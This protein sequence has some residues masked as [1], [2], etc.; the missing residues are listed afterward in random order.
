MLIDLESIPGEVANESDVCVV[1]GGIAGLLIAQRLAARGMTVHVLEAGGL[2]LEERSQALYDAEMGG[3]RHLGTTEGRFRTLGGSS[4]RWGGQLLPYT[5]DIFVPP[6]KAPSQQWPMDDRELTPYYAEIQQMMGTDALPFDA[7]L[8]PALGHEPVE[9]SPAIELRY[10][11]WIPFQKRNLAKTVGEKL[12]TD[13][14]VTIFTHANVAG[15]EGDGGKI[16]EALVLT[17]GGRSF[18]FRAKV[19]VVATGT[20]ES[21]RLM[22]LSSGVPNEHDQVGRYFHDH[23]SFAAA[24]FRGAARAR[25]LEKLGPFLVDGTLHTCKMEASAELR[26]RENLI[27]VMAHVV[28][29]EPEDSGVAAVRGMLTALQ[30]GRLREGLTQNLLPML[31]G[32]GDVIRLA[33]Y[34]R[35][36]KRRAVSQR[37]AVRLQIDSEQ[38]PTAETRIR[39]SEAKDALGLRKAVV[40]WRVHDAER[41]TAVRFAP[42][43]AAELERLGMKPEA[44]DA[45]LSAGRPKMVD[46]Y[47]A[48]GGLRMGTD[49][50]ESVVDTKLRVH[51][52]ENLYVASCAVYPAGGSSNPTFTLIALALRF[53]DSLAL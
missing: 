21:S 31:R 14:R 27:A 43:I 46:T 3:E 44:W 8:L 11:K 22:L 41:D 5:P 19:F 51:G 2:E 35:W 7:G 24:E 48:M 36:K 33:V 28:M 38:L 50:S 42:V 37:A 16:T 9:F 26:A 18:R 30:N 6:P 32:L 20:I 29:L 34:A 13:E 40:D 23:V 53:A 17:Y 45:G 12:K 47:H 25:M 1:G 4:T 52:L 10:S 49:P 15:L 39:L